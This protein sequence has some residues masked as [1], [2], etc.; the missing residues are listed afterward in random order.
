MKVPCYHCNVTTDL[1]INFDLVDFVCPNCYTV[2]RN[3]N[4]GLK[5][6]SRFDSVLYPNKFSVGQ[7]AFLKGEDYVIT[8]F[9][10][11][12]GDYNFQWAEYILTKQK[13]DF[14]YL[15]EADGHWILLNEVAFD[16]KV[17]NHPKRIDYDGQSFS[18]YEYSNPKVVSAQGYF[19]F[20]IKIK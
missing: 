19:D 15:S 3:D 12:K 17:G 14:L 5:F 8:G 9:L 7:K 2:Y 6:E 11:K 10:I 18:I 1:E 4:E 16:K 20:D 13:G